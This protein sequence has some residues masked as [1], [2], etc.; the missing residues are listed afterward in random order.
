MG[1]VTA[2]IEA[3]AQ[4]RVAGLGQRQKHGLVGL[5]AGVGLDIGEVAVK[6]LLGPLDGEFLGDIDKLAAAIVAPARIAL[7]ILVGHH[8]ALRFQNGARDDVLRS[9]QLDLVALAS[10]LALDGTEQFRIGISQGAVERCI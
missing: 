1:Q 2:G 10:E 7:G 6:Q 4:Q 8:R 5:A 9:D 3:H